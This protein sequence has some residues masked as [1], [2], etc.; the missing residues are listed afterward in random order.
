MDDQPLFPEDRDA[1]AA[2]LALGLLDGAERTAALRLSLADPA[3]AAE[4]EAWK[5]RLSPLLDTIPEATPSPRV[6]DAVEARIGA[7]APIA[8][9]A[10]ASSVRS[11]RLWRG[12]ALLSGTLAAGLALFIVLRPAD[13]TPPTQVAVSQLADTSGGA[14]MTV[15]YDG[16]TG[17][18]RLSPATLERIGG[19]PELWVIPADGIPRSLGIVG[20]AG[21]TLTVDAKLRPFFKGGVTLAVTLEDPATAPHAAP[22]A[23]PVLTG[24]LTII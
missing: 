9:P 4:V 13:V 16:Q 1:L 5:T 20:T 11:L 18:L 7:A 8:L 10:A 14:A 24:K 6:W 22:T 15:A 23:L 3:F 12:S 21:Q 17:E 2:E 19:S